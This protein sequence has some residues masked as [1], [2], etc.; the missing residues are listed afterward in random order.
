MARAS[1]PGNAYDANPARGLRGGDGGYGLW[2]GCSSFFDASAAFRKMAARPAIPIQPRGRGSRAGKEAADPLSSPA[3]KRRCRPGAQIPRRGAWPAKTERACRASL[4]FRCASWRAGA[5]P[6]AR[7]WH[8]KKGRFRRTVPLPSG[9]QT[10]ALFA[11]FIPIDVDAAVERAG[12]LFPRLGA[13]LRLPGR[14]LPLRARAS[15]AA[16]VVLVVV[17]AGF[18]AVRF[19]GPARMIG[20][21]RLRALPIHRADHHMAVEVFAFAPALCSPP[22][23][24]PRY[25]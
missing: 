17:P 21:A 5:L 7:P 9:I 16:V 1:G 24:A 22:Q 14:P 19:A 20:L 6:R 15:A 2:H 13:L 11:V 3:W 25:G 10:T 8:D 12:G 4:C 23:S 18:I